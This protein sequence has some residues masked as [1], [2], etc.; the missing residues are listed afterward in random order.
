M[1]VRERIGSPWWSRFDWI[2]LAATLMLALFGLV[3]IYSASS[4]PGPFQPSSFVIKQS[5]YLLVGLSLMAFMAT[6]DYRFFEGLTW[7]AYALTL[8]L[9]VVVLLLGH[10]A[11]GSTRWIDLGPFPLQPSELAKLSMVLVLARL[12]A[13]KPRY[14]KPSVRFLL[15][16]GLMLPVLGL[17]FAQPDLGTTLVIAAIWLALVLV[18]GTRLRYLVTLALLSV[19]LGL[20]AWKVLL[21]PYQ[22]A[23]ILVFLDPYSSPLDDGYNIIQATI[24]V[25]AGGLQ[26][27]GYL[28]GSQSQLHYL[29]VQHTD[30]IAS[31]IAEEF[32][33]VGMLALLLLYGIVLWRMIRVASL[34]RDRYGELIAAG[35]ATVML[36]QV[37]VNI[38]MNVR[39]MPVTGIPLP[40]ISYGGSSLVTLL[41]AEGLLQSV[42]LRHKKLDI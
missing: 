41:A 17:V 13:V 32:G 18:A 39:L 10:T 2:L 8:G 37:F 9:L 15:S 12:L 42:L 14:Q 28:S 1:K 20:L 6:I 31:V 4:E 38:G 24:S 29:R 34:A 7:P 27:Q 22:V 36:F 19:P 30:F 11:Y 23:R 3:M 33:F 40:F 5:V 21:K 16:L 35:I 25:G 26:G